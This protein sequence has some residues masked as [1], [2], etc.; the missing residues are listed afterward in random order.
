MLKSISQLEDSSLSFCAT[1]SQLFSCYGEQNNSIKV[2]NNFERMNKRDA[3]N[4][5][6]H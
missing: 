4:A 2:S 1:L 3:N 5:S 6:V